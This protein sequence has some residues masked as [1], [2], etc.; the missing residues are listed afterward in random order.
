MAN[1]WGVSP[2]PSR[3]QVKMPGSVLVCPPTVCV[4]LV[5]MCPSLSSTMAVRCAPRCPSWP[6]CVDM[7]M[8]S[9]D[10]CICHEM[11]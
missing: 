9:D 4:W 11:G 5:T 10:V 7:Y 2:I 8:M 3:P 6:A 1:L